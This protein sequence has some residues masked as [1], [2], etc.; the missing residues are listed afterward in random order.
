MVS[1]IP[2]V[3]ILLN[4]SYLRQRDSVAWSNLYNQI[5][6]S[7]QVVNCPAVVSALVNAGILPVDSGQTE[8]YYNIKP[9]SNIS[10]LGPDYDTVKGHGIAYR[11]SIRNAISRGE[12][13][14][15]ILTDG[16]GNLVSF[17]VVKQYYARAET[18]TIDMPQTDQ[19]WVIGIWEPIDK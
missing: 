14:K 19:T 5:K 3:H 16:Y 10:M 8:Y 18:I 4:P 9:Y 17:D 7:N 12:F 1:K 11:R 2:V 6:A 15:L 13:D